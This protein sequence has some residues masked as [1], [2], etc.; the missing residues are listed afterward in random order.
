MGEKYARDNSGQK[1]LLTARNLLRYNRSIQSIVAKA[2]AAAVNPLA[3]NRSRRGERTLESAHLPV[4]G[5]SVRRCSDKTRTVRDS[6]VSGSPRKKIAGT[7][8]ERS[9]APRLRSSWRSVG[10]VGRG[11]PFPALSVNP[12]GQ[13]SLPGARCLGHAPS[14]SGR[15]SHAAD[16]SRAAMVRRQNEILERGEMFGNGASSSPASFGRTIAKHKDAVFSPRR[17]AEPI[18]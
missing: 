10:T 13:R 1:T 18:G 3:R 11:H 9:H 12:S 14:P 5:E 4:L 17:P 16:I 8:P 15:G 6:R 7:S 2:Q